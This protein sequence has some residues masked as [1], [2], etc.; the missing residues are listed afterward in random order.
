MNNIKYITGLLIFVSFST[1][2]YAAPKTEDAIKFR[3]SGMMFMRWNMGIIK[4][5]V[6]TDPQSYNRESVLVSSQV[7]AAIANSGM[8]RLYPAN[9]AE[10]KGWHNTRVKP[11]YFSEQD[12][13]KKLSQD[14]IKEAN[15]MLEVAKQAD[16][17]RIKTQFNKLFNTCKSCHKSYRYKK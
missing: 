13:A 14:F 15:A 16:L 10:G 11:A 6:I 17:V 1:S 2:L 7:I 4:K 5:Q 12:N 9:S 8:E 3:Q